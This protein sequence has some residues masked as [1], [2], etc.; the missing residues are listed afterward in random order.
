MDPIIRLIRR[1][2][3]AMRYRRI[4]QCSFRVAWDKARRMG[5]YE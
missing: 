4:F 2:Q 3:R 5:Q 1:F